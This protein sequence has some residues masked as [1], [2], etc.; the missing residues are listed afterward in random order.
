MSVPRWRARLRAAYDR[1]AP[2]LVIACLLLA[3][4]FASVG[5][6]AQSRVNAAQDRQRAHDVQALLECFDAYASAASASSTAVR[7]ATQ[8]RDEATTVRDDAL[9]AE[10]RAFQTVVEHLLADA[11]TPGDVQVLA[12]ALAARSTAARRLDAAQAGLDR[13]RREHPVPPP[14]EFCTVQP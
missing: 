6:Y 12:D 14:S 9:N 13:A 5:M 3:S 10:G 11:V 1:V 7:R 8:V 2:I 4:L